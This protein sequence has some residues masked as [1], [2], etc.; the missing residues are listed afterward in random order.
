MSG[1]RNFRARQPRG[2]RQAAQGTGD[3]RRGGEHVVLTR[4][5]EQWDLDVGERAVRQEEAD[6]RYQQDR[7]ADAAIAIGGHRKRQ[8]EKVGVGSPEASTVDVIGY[9][10]GMPTRDRERRVCADRLAHDGE[11]LALQSRPEL[12]ICERSIES[13]PDVARTML[14]E[15]GFDSTGGVTERVVVAVVTRMLEH[16]HGKA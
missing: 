2:V 10:A 6:R 7:C 13:E 12:G 11:P 4:A 9:R 3:L 14:Q 1:A 5:D 15:Y 8:L 16:R